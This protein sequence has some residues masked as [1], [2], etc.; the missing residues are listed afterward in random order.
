MAYKII[1]DCIY[2]DLS[3]REIVCDSASDVAS[4]PASTTGST[5]V[6]CDSGDIYV[7]NASGEWVKFGG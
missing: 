2:G 1:N 5:A 4:L 3:R 7:V 6:V